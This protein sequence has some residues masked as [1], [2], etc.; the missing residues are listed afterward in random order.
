MEAGWAGV[1]TLPRV[2]TLVS[3][4]RLRMEPHPFCQRLTRFGTSVRSMTI[5][6]ELNQQ[7]AVQKIGGNA[8]RLDAI[9]EVNGDQ[10]LALSFYCSPDGKEETRLVYSPAHRE[11]RIDRTKSSL[12]PRQETKPHAAPLILQKGERLN[13]TLYLDRSMVEVYANDTCC[14]TTRVYPN[15]ADSTGIR[16]AGGSRKTIVSEIRWRPITLRVS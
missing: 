7:I 8:G 6:D 3:G 12:D 1:Q 10:D 2:L 5:G 16:V 9:F 14:L 4:N 15:Q 13:F 11:V